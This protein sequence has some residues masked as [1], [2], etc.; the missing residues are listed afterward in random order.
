MTMIKN[1]LICS[2]ETL[3]SNTILGKQREPLMEN[4]FSD[5]SSQAAHT[6]FLQPKDTQRNRQRSI[7][8][9]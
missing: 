7:N 2:L 9:V 8:T 6:T 5:P 1:V 3:E 4:M